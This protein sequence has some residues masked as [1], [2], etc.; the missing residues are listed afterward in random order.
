M[1][2]PPTPSSLPHTATSI[3]RRKFLTTTAGAGVMIAGTAAA[4][5]AGVKER[6][7]YAIVGVGSR[8]GMYR[9]AIL[10]SYADHCELVSFCDN[11]EGRLKLAQ[12]KARKAAGV[13][14]P[15]FLDRDFDRMIAETKPA[16]VI[17]TSKDSTHD[18]Y[19]IRAMELGCDVMTEKPMTVDETK[20]RAILA[21]QEKTGRKIIVTFNYRYSPPR[22]QI[23]DMLMK[24]VIGDVLSVDFHWMLDTM[25]GADYF[26]RWHGNKANS[27]GLMVHK[28]THHFD[29]VNWWL[30]A[31]P[32]NVLA[33]GKREFYTPAMAK[34]LGLT[35]HHE[36][37][38][39]C[40][41]AKKCS[42]HLDLAANKG[43]KELYL[44]QE[45]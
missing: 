39:T 41:E 11:N 35:S 43:L 1:E 25:H 26:R 14:I 38:K 32:V 29:L 8:S 22:T 37:C 19:I 36:R 40:P 30:S 18:Q 5:T 7:R 6:K 21:A 9:D 33:M 31:N 24:G 23:K 12:L 27:G 17:V 28:A 3:S 4:Q 2:N 45:S 34:R 13:E 16:V 10:K 44:D 20:C 15:I 42:F